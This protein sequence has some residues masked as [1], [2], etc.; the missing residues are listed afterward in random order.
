MNKYE[1]V[2]TPFYSYFSYID[3]IKIMV[4]LLNGFISLLLSNIFIMFICEE[5]AT[6]FVR[7][8]IRNYCNIRTHCSKK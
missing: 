3:I 7:P 1:T 8:Q 2:L 5:I 4:I 6:G